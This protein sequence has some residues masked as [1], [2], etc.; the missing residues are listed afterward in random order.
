MSRRFL[1]VSGLGFP[2]ERVGGAQ[3]SVLTTA[4][5]LQA[6]GHAVHICF[7]QEFHSSRLQRATRR[8]SGR[9]F[10]RRK[11]NGV[12]FLVFNRLDITGFSVFMNNVRDSIDR[13]K[14]DV[15]IVDAGRTLEAARFLAHFH[16]L[17]V[18]IRDTEGLPVNGPDLPPLPAATYIANSEFVARRIRPLLQEAP[19]VFFPAID[20][21]QYLPTGQEVDAGSE[22]LF[23]NPTVL[24]GL[25]LALEIAQRLPHLPFCFLES[26]PLSEPDR[27]ALMARI[28]SLGNVRFHP[29]VAD[30]RA[31]F[32]QSRMLLVP[33]LW[34]E[35]WGRVITEAQTW[36][37][38][39]LA[40]QT[41]GIPEALGSG[42]ILMPGEATASEWSAQ[43]EALYND[44]E[45]QA[46]LRS[47]GRQHAERLEASNRSLID[48]LTQL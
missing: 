35:A 9:P 1:F 21:R 25:D 22:I 18:F 40:R 29:A 4:Q 14:P 11:H 45:M 26:W 46:Q 17:C 20:L 28:E 42:G 44:A 43:I 3:I 16:P 30:V 34:E 48:F 24:K 23:I 27:A 12:Q 7:P 15:V 13:I 47:D 10:L 31:L 5:R 19:K 32:A 8:F 2:P 41:G 6:R 36:G 37:L 39:I 38:P 33:S